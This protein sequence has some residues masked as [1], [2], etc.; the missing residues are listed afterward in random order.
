MSLVYVGCAGA[1]CCFFARRRRQTRCALVTGVQTCALPIFLRRH[2]ILRV[3]AP[4]GEGFAGAGG[5]A[6]QFRRRPVREPEGRKEGLFCVLHRVRGLIEP[7]ACESDRIFNCGLEGQWC[8][9]DRHRSKINEA[10]IW[11]HL[12]GLL[13]IC[14]S[15][16]NSRRKIGGKVGGTYVFSRLDKSNILVDRDKHIRF[17]KHRICL[18]YSPLYGAETATF[19]D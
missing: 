1:S 7:S 12:L 11:I 13:P 2:E 17:V 9:Y 14:K 5:V 15:L 19:R 16:T 18:A 4:G 3:Q 8:D 10:Y 6:E